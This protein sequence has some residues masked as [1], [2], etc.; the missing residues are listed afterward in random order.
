MEALNSLNAKEIATQVKQ[1]ISSKSKIKTDGFRNYSML[2]I[3]V[4]S[5]ERDKVPPE[6]AGIMLSWLHTMV[7]NSKR[8]FSGIHFVQFRNIKI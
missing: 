3:C 5:V 6:Q 7:F 1:R 4:E 2:F 8:T